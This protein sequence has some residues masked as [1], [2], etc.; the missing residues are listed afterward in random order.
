MCETQAQ[1]LKAEIVDS[2]SSENDIGPGI[3]DLL[4]ALLCNVRLALPD[5][6]QLLRVGNQDL[7]AH[8]HLGLLKRKVEAGNPRIGHLLDHR[9][10]GYGAVESIAVDKDALAGGFAVSL[11]YINSLDG[12]SSR[13][14]LVCD[15]DEL[16]SLDNH[17]GKEVGI[18]TD[19]FA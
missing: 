6:I 12:V 7:D 3:E 10:R 11:Q 17:G 1:Y 8:L 15:F 19:D 13:L 2:S 16:S 18:S 4:N 5:S 14:G 9:L